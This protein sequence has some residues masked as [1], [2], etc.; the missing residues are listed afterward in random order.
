[1]KIIEIINEDVNSNLVYH[2]VNNGNTATRIL[3]SG[4]L[5]L[6]EPFAYDDEEEGGN[7]SRNHLSVTRNQYLHFPYGNGIVQFVLD[8]DA[9]KKGGWQVRPKIGA[10][11]PYKYETEERVYHK[12]DKPV[13]VKPPYVVGIQ[14]YPGLDI[15]PEVIE[16]TKQLGIPVTPMKSKKEPVASAAQSTKNR[17]RSYG[18]GYLIGIEK[19]DSG[20]TITGKHTI[21]GM[22]PNPEPIEPYINIPDE[23][24]AIKV[25]DKLQSMVDSKVDYRDITP[26]QYHRTWEKGRYKLQAGDKEFQWPDL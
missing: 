17:T 4:K 13:P 9:L 24:T 23:A 7:E 12:F 6:T 11:M 19:T 1:M 2:G 25:R 22:P 14:I 10:G 15:P 18:M 5:N 21:P 3:N 16:K 20:Y 26:T 8:K